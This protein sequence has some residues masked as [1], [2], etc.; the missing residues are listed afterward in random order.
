MKILSIGGQETNFEF[1]VS[2][3]DT[4]LLYTILVRNLLAFWASEPVKSFSPIVRIAIRM[5]V[6]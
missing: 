2:L 4:I 1:V 5:K 3:I 6:S